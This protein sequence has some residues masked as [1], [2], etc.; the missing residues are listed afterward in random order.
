MIVGCGLTQLHTKI[1]NCESFSVYGRSRS[2][3]SYTE[4]AWCC[5]WHSGRVSDAFY[6]LVSCHCRHNSLC[7][8]SPL[9]GSEVPAVDVQSSERLVAVV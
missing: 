9:L 3:G 6:P 2:M 8:F 7:A 4:K 5:M 1:A